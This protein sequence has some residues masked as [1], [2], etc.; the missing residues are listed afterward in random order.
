[1][2]LAGDVPRRQKVDYVTS[3][4]V[5]PKPSGQ[6]TF[7]QL[8]PITQL[9][10][11]GGAAT[12]PVA[13][14]A[15]SGLY[16]A[17]TLINLFDLYRIDAIRATIRPNNTAIGLADPTVTNLVPLYWVLDYNDGASLSSAAAATEYDNCMVLS[18]AESATRT[19][20][21]RYQVVAKS[22]GGTNFLSDYGQWIDTSS[23]DIIHYGMKFFIPPGAATQT[24]LQT[25]TL[26]LEY[27]ITFRQVVG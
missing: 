21:P 13:T 6:L 7:R 22:V 25:W 5:L 12:A 26:E 3:S 4:V 16:G 24:F 2:D 10:V 14:F 18:P 23:S 15:L 11:T 27:F 1:M 8:G 9:S 19:F 17:G 20:I